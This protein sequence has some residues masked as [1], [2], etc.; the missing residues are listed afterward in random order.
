M[1]SPNSTQIDLNTAVSKLFNLFM[2]TIFSTV[3]LKKVIVNPF[4]YDVLQT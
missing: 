3:V 1:I 4:S 2:T